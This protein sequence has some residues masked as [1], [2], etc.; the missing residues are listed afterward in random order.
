VVVA[1]FETGQDSERDRVGSAPGTAR[2]Y[3]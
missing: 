3:C 2:K 1:S